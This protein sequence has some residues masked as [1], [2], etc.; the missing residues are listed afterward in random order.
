MFA[1]CVRGGQD[2]EKER[3]ALVFVVQGRRIDGESFLVAMKKQRK[4]KIKGL[5]EKVIF[6]IGSQ[7][8]S[9]QFGGL[10]ITA[11]ERSWFLKCT[12]L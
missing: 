5:T 4:S 1:I 6:C 2:G 9:L 8:R 10:Q 3:V 11:S 12:I 7:K